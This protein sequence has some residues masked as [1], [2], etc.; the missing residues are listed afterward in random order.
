MYKIA[1]CCI[2]QLHCSSIWI[3]QAKEARDYFHC[4]EFKIKIDQ[5]L[6]CKCVIKKIAGKKSTEMVFNWKHFQ[7]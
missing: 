4:V 2:P 3:V 6:I 5:V 1:V 7:I